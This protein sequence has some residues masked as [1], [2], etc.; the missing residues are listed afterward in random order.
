MN[1]FQ[2]LFKSNKARAERYKAVRA[3]NLQLDHDKSGKA[4]G[5]LPAE[6]RGLD[7]LRAAVVAKGG[8]PDKRWGAKRLQAEI[9][10]LS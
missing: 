5:S 8:I 4:G 10:R 1:I 3:K 7:E 9:D 6:V 2:R